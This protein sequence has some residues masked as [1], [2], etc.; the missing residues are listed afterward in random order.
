MFFWLRFFFSLL[1]KNMLGLRNTK[2]EPMKKLAIPYAGPR[3]FP[4]RPANLAQ[5]RHKIGQPGLVKNELKA[6]NISPAF[7]RRPSGVP[8]LIEQ[9][10]SSSPS[11][12]KHLKTH[13]PKIRRRLSM[14]GGTRKTR[15]ELNMSPIR[16]DG[17]WNGDHTEATLKSILSGMHL[18]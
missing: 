7:K 10:P 14:R 9:W 16:P 18:I 2:P 4:N 3:T 13:E 12:K 1:I 8:R 11:S 15:P 6:S 5:P 17:S